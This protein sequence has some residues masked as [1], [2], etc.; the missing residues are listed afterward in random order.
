MKLCTRV[1]QSEGKSFALCSLRSS[2]SVHTYQCND[3][4]QRRVYDHRNNYFDN[5]IAPITQPKLFK[6]MHGASSYKW[7]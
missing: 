7:S 1:D 4:L 2:L 3:E 6:L 5:K